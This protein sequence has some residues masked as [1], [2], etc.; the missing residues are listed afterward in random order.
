MDF[1][2]KI[3]DPTNKLAGL[4]ITPTGLPKYASFGSLY[5]DNHDEEYHE[6][7]AWVKVPT[8]E[9]DAVFLLSIAPTL[10]SAPRG[11]FDEDD[12]VF[13]DILSI[14][15]DPD[16]DKDIKPDDVGGF[17]GVTFGAGMLGVGFA[18]GTWASAATSGRSRATR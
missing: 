14:G 17:G 9:V 4:R 3:T 13:A 8:H 18:R 6:K 12:S 5:L 11:E 2:E 16:T 15:V 1:P 10:L 7:I